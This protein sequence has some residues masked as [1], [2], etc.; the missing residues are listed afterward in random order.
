MFGKHKK[1]QIEY[2]TWNINDKS[3]HKNGHHSK[4]EIIRSHFVNL[5]FF[6]TIF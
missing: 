1:N 2:D 3:K 4:I 5:L 6:L